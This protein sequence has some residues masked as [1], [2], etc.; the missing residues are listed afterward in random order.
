EMASA[1]ILYV[2]FSIAMDKQIDMLENY[3]EETEDILYLIVRKPCT[4]VVIFLRRKKYDMSCDQSMVSS[5]TQTEPSGNCL[6]IPLGRL[7]PFIL[8]ELEFTQ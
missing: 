4:V 7:D 2:V 3:E 8:K 5:P 1:W 6:G